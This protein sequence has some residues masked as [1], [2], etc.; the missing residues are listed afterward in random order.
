MTGVSNYL[1]R[2]HNTIALLR[3][4]NAEK[5]YKLFSREFLMVAKYC[6]L[7]DISSFHNVTPQSLSRIRKTI[8]WA[9]D[10]KE[11]ETLSNEL[12]VVHGKTEKYKRLKK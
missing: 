11:I 10:E 9:E 2:T 1:G 8:K 5:R 12:K 7:S 6:K 3:T 4:L